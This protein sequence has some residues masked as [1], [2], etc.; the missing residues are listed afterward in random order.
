[1]NTT[2]AQAAAWVATIGF[3][4]MMCL[5]TLLALG[6]PLGQLA[7]GGKYDKLPPGLRI[8]SLLSAGIFAFGTLCM[9]E[10]ADILVVLDR[11]TLVTYA[12][13]ILAALF[14]LSTLANLASP[15]KW[16]KRIMTPIA[17]TLS[18]SCLI[19]AIASFSDAPTSTPTQ[20]PLLRQIDE[21]EKQWREQEIA[22]Y[23][24]EVL[25]VRGTWHAQVHLITVR[26]G[27]VVD[28]SASCTPAPAELGEW[29][30]LRC[31]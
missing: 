15:S 16:E 27:Q 24:I 31:L 8:A 29:M 30:L 3:I 21:A 26:N 9:L 2:I 10:R 20:E 17:L 25:T 13:W 11:P 12:V 28:E 19:V 6:F 7:W 14:G 18:L 22:S 4:G 5:Q 23:R 1:M